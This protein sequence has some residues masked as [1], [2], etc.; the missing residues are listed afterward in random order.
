LRRRKHACSFW[1]GRRAGSAASRARSGS[2]DAV[3]RH[4]SATGPLTVPLRRA[5]VFVSRP[6]RGP[7][8]AQLPGTRQNKAFRG[9][10]C[11]N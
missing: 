2:V 5:A 1:R 3:K 10:R 9:K 8:A 4:V 11:A 6:L 7:Q